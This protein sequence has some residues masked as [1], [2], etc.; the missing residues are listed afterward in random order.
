[1]AL[2]R[3]APTPNQQHAKI[4]RNHV[5]IILRYEKKYSTAHRRKSQPKNNESVSK[6]LGSETTRIDMYEIGGGGWPPR[7]PLFVQAQDV[8]SVS[9][10]A[11]DVPSVS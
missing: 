8:P 5:I 10:E 3:K 2:A 4:N 9:C 1:M 6:G 11:Q 7:P